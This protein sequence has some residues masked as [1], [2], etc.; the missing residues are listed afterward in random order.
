MKPDKKN[1]KLIKESAKET[2]EARKKRVSSGVRFRAAIFEDK[3]HKLK[4]KAI[5]KED[6]LL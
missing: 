4:D 3:R 2:P 5:E 1:Y 6:N